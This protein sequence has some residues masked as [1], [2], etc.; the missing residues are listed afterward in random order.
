MVGS[1][2][3]RFIVLA[4]IGAVIGGPVLVGRAT[5]VPPPVPLRTAPVT[6]GSLTQTVAVSGSVTASSLI[7]LNFKL[8]GRLA[9]ILVTVGDRVVKDQ[10]IARLDPSDLQIALRSAQASLA[11]AQ[12]RYDQVIAGATTED[13]VVAQRQFE[14][15]KANYASMKSAFENSVLGA[16]L[17]LR[18]FNDR[19]PSSRDQVTTILGNL[20]GVAQPV[21]TQQPP[22]PTDPPN[23][24]PEPTL[25]TAK[26][27]ARAAIVNVNQA[28]AGDN[29]FNQDGNQCVCNG[30]HL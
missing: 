3:G 16:Q 25:G 6:R 5:T 30:H 1:W 29:Y 12:A 27:D 23:L 20:N 10:A 18:S 13:I 11:S 2:R 24:T 8:S 15:V 7:R 17:D 9:E 4:V 26:T 14:K 22:T 21:A 28:G 19:L